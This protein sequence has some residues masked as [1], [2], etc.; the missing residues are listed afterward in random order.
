MWDVTTP[1]EQIDWL[2]TL[3]N[4]PHIIPGV[5]TRQRQYG[6]SPGADPEAI[7]IDLY[8]GVDCSGSMGNP[9]Q[10]LSYPV[11][12]GVIIALS[13]LRVGVARKGGAVGRAG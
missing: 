6:T 11:L 3:L 4:S 2:G 8:L 7:P 5:T 1:L 13:A 9:A 12:A 10:H